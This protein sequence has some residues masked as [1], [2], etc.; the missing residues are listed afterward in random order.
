MAECKRILRYKVLSLVV[1]KHVVC[2]C[3]CVCTQTM[4]T[5]L[6]MAQKQETIRESTH[7]NMPI[8]YAHGGNSPGLYSGGYRFE[9]WNRTPTILPHSFCQQC[10]KTV[11]E[12][13]L[14]SP[15][16]T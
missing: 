4:K 6:K 11:L 3:V 14:L 2:V 7:L 5:G 10:Q 9:S 12:Y 8:K 13:C 15:K 16:F 1:T